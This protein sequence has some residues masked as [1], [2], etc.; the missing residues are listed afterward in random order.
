MRGDCAVGAAWCATHAGH[1]ASIL[2]YQTY[3]GGPV[4]SLPVASSKSAKGVERADMIGRLTSGLI[5][6]GMLALTAIW[7][8][9]L[10]RGTLW[11]MGR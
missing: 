4:W 2:R 6:A 11:L 8:L 10:I 3:R 5:A 9:L 7:C 1:L